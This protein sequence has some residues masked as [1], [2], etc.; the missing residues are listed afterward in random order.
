MRLIAGRTADT[1]AAGEAGVLRF[2]DPTARKR[3]EVSFGQSHQFGVI[4]LAS[5]DQGQA[6]GPIL[7]TPPAMEIFDG[8]G[9]NA[10]FVAQDGAAER[11][12]GEGGGL[13]VVEDDVAGR[14]DRKSTRLN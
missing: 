11:L 5:R 13:E 6:A 10:R 1:I 8:D 12:V 7:A 3:D 14:V 2:L 9:G 4:D